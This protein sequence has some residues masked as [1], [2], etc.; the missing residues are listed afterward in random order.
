[1]TPVVEG[2]V[3][4]RSQDRGEAQLEDAERAET[5]SPVAE[6]SAPRSLLRDVTTLLEPVTSPIV[7]AV[8]PATGGIVTSNVEQVAERT[9]APVVEETTQAEAEPVVETTQAEAD[10]KSTRLNSS[11]VSITYA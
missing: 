6:R 4:Q 8:E 2:K 5:G 10:L 11:H 7:D 1:E 9:L 3:S